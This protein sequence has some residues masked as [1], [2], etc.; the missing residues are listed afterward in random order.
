MY[1]SRPVMLRGV[2]C[3]PIGGANHSKAELM[4]PD[5]SGSRLATVSNRRLCWPRSVQTTGKYRVVPGSPYASPAD[6]ASSV[7]EDEDPDSLNR[8]T[9]QTRCHAF[10]S[11][12]HAANCGRRTQ[13]TH[14]GC[15]TSLMA[16]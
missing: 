11:A 6:R 5:P 14:A 9:P 10:S 12:Q 8:Q 7:S 16:R 3:S 13:G 1:E 2:A 15:S 4:P